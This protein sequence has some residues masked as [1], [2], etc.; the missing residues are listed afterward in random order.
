MQ[1]LHS[2]WLEGYPTSCECLYCC[3]AG[4]CLARCRSLQK[5]RQTA[6]YSNVVHALHVVA[7][8][9]KFC[10]IQV[11]CDVNILK[12]KEKAN[13]P[14]ISS[15]PSSRSVPS[16]KPSFWGLDSLFS[17]LTLP[18]NGRRRHRS[19]L[20]RSVRSWLPSGQSSA[21]ERWKGACQRAW[22]RSGS[23]S[24]NNPCVC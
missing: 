10:E 4:P 19:D 15:S 22:R 12:E 3:G 2:F 7:A 8:H 23:N 6:T 21:A 9:S 1:C 16:F 17:C 20:K 24:F 13:W 5:D 14:S 18:E 11:N